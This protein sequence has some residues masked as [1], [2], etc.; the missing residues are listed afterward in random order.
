MLLLDGRCR[1]AAST[2]AGNALPDVRIDDESSPRARYADS[3]IAIER[4]PSGRASRSCAKGFQEHAKQNASGAPTTASVV[5][6]RPSGYRI[7]AREYASSVQMIMLARKRT[8]RAT[9]RPRGKQAHPPSSVN[10]NGEPSAR[11]S[12]R[13]ARPWLFEATGQHLSHRGVVLGNRRAHGECNATAKS[14]GRA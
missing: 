14:E 12:S 1:Q 2:I 7:E 8:A 6:S 10:A 5:P 4:T 13:C 9:L 3:L 11:I